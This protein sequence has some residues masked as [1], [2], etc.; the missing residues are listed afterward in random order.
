[1]SAARAGD[2]R[3]IVVDFTGR[4]FRVT[5]NADGSYVEHLTRTVRQTA[6]YRFSGTKYVLVSEENPVHDIAG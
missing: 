1:M 4:H 6:R 5:E 3:D 2:Y